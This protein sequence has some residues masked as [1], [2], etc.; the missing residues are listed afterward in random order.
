MIDRKPVP[1]VAA[2]APTE[3]AHAVD[4]ATRALYLANCA[5]CH[6]EKGDGEGVTQLDRKARSFLDGGFSY[7]NT[8]EA[9]VRSIV[10]GIPG[11]PMPSFEKALKQ[12]QVAALADYVIALGPERIVVDPSESEMVVRDRPLVVYG[13][14]PPIVEGGKEI[15]RGLAIG[16]PD[17]LTFEYRT[18]D[19][20]LVRVRAGG[21]VNRTD[22]GGRGGTTLEMLGTPVWRPGAEFNAATVGVE[23][24]GEETGPVRARLSATTIRDGEAEIE[25]EFLLEGNSAR[26]RERCSAYRNGIGSGYVIRRTVVAERDG[27]SLRTLA[28]RAADRTANAAAELGFVGAKVD[29]KSTL[30]VTR[31]RSGSGAPTWSSRPPRLLVPL[32]AGRETS[33]DVHVLLDLDPR[34]DVDDPVALARLAEEFAS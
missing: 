33:V 28:F 13:K 23:R 18:D 29:G 26:V 2:V 10:H 19:V 25:Y 14:L 7:G 8:K 30:I 15:A 21:F 5:Q 20:Q 17:G 4:G 27:L 22:W 16:T 32:P 11:T 6:G 3:S 31:L 34:I 24:V 12:E 1:Q 9:I